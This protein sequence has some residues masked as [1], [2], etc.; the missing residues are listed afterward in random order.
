[1]PVD[2]QK[3]SLMFF[4]SVYWA[5]TW[6]IE[7]NEGLVH[8][9]S[10]A[11]KVWGKVIFYTCLSVILFTGGEYLGRYPPGPGTPPHQVH[12]PDQ[13]HPRDQVHSPG[14]G[15]PPG[16]RYTHLWPGTPPR[17]QVHPTGTRYTPGPDTP[18]TRYTP[19]SRYPPGAGTPRSRHTPPTRHP[20][21]TAHAG[22]YGLRAGGTHPT[23]MHS[24]FKGLHRLR[25]PRIKHGS[26]LLIK[27]SVRSET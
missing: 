1:M 23:G 21:G 13:V 12:P 2:W 15:T 25:T 19:Q 20:S 24:C 6:N 3:I 11:N 4:I 7:K 17:D 14:P 16:T 10:P 5:N 26:K 9:L 8:F 27:L 18:G 22:R